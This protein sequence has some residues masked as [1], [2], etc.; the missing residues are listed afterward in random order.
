MAWAAQ[1]SCFLRLPSLPGY[2]L[3]TITTQHRSARLSLHKAHHTSLRHQEHVSTEIT[4]L[5]FI[6]LSIVCNIFNTLTFTHPFS[7]ALNVATSSAEEM[8]APRCSSAVS[9][10]RTAGFHMR[11]PYASSSWSPLWATS[12]TAACIPHSNPKDN[13]KRKAHPK[14]RRGHVHYLQLV[15]SQKCHFSSLFPK[16]RAW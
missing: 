8:F 3:G 10:A 7:F 4:R 5:I 13:R 12:Q 16:Y 11:S 9:Q 6:S 14:W 2:R 15:F 1:Q